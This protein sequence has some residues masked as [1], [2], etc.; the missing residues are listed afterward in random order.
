MDNKSHGARHE[1]SAERSAGLTSVSPNRIRA[2]NVLAGT[3]D[4]DVRRAI[5]GEGGARIPICRGSNAHDGARDRGRI[6]AGA[7][8]FVT[9]RR[10]EH[11]TSLI[12]GGNRPI[13]AGGRLK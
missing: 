12:G 1:W 6:H 7:G 8:V 13:E 9:C 11:D 2:N 10:Y 4:P 5:V 3:G